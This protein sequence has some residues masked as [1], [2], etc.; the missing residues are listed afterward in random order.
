MT[1]TSGVAD[2]IEL[3]GGSLS[4]FRAAVSIACRRTG[5]GPMRSPPRRRGAVIWYFGE[6]E[7]EAL[8]AVDDHRDPC[9]VYLREVAELNGEVC[10]NASD[11]LGV[12]PD[13]R[14]VAIGEQLDGEL[15]FFGEAVPA[16]DEHATEADV[17]GNGLHASGLVVFLL[18]VPDAHAGRQ[19]DAPGR[20]TLRKEDPVGD[21]ELELWLVVC[22]LG[23]DAA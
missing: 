13:G 22:C 1:A 8:P 18:T 15:G 3:S 12:A 6:L 9:A 10:R 14:W 5:V 16:L 11:E 4:M 7:A 23:G 21:N 2:A 17:D 20:A 19:T